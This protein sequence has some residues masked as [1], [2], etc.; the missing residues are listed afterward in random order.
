MT[1]EKKS[2]RAVL[3]SNVRAL[4]TAATL[5][6]EGLSDI[7][8]FHRTFVSQVETQRANVTLESLERLADALKVRPSK[9]LDEAAEG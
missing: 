6:Q 5:S 7:A 3:A 1:I 2:A 4:R 9:L 8:G